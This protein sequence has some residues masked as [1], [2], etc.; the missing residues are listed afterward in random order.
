MSVE[1]APVFNIL[2]HPEHERFYDDIFTCLLN[3]LSRSR[4]T[5]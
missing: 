4:R 3:V 2:I 1:D 5:L